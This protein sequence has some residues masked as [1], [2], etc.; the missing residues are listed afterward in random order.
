MVNRYFKHLIKN[1]Y[2][3]LHTTPGYCCL[4]GKNKIAAMRSKV[5]FFLSF[6][7]ITSLFFLVGVARNFYP[8]PITHLK[9]AC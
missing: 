3:I 1:S 7:L 6:V 4:P 2:F 8:I 5:K 9:K